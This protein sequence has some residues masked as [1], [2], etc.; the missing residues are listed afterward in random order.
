M[1]ILHLCL[2]NFYIDNFSYQENLL[3]KFHKK[4]GYDVEIIASTF[5]FDNSGKGYYTNIPKCYINKDG[6]FVTRLKNKFIKKLGIF[7]GTYEAIKKSNPDIIFIHGLQFLDII[8]V[9][10]YIKLNKNVKIFVDNH[11]DF[12]NSATNWLSR[13]ILHKLIWRLCAKMIEPY[14][15]KFYGVLPARVDF[16]KNVYKIPEEKIELLLMGAE[17]EKVNIAKDPN[18]KKAIRS[19]YDIKEDDF[20]IM[21]GGK[22]DKN[23]WQTLL[24][25]EAVKKISNSKVKL[26]I[27][28]SVIN[29]LR[30]KFESLIDD[31]KIKYAG[32]ISSDDSYNY[33]AASDLVVFPGKHSVFWEQVAGLGIPMIVKYLPGITHI[34]Y[35]GNIE[36]LYNDSAI[37]IKDKIEKIIVDKNKYFKMKKRAE[38]ISIFFMYSKIA[39][40]SLM[41]N[42]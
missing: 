40:K 3:S 8:H 35:G 20:L 23:K 21:T 9:I 34:D 29:E 33:F 6:I 31:E 10:R 13:N 28:G 1:K 19:K 7:M 15:I 22:I 38:D 41:I 37:E 18:I 2:G 25:M 17:D 27:F 42:V 24:L 32:W 39:E 11:A 14:T 4:L 5:T 26:I 16:L 30:D 36:F 12:L